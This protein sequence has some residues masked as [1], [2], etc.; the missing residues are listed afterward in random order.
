MHFCT[1]SSA[2][3]AAK[4]LLLGQ[5]DLLVIRKTNSLS[6]FVHIF[7][8]GRKSSGS[9]WMAQS[10]Q[11]KAEQGTEHP[12]PM[13]PGGPTQSLT[14][15]S[16]PRT[17]LLFMT[18]PQS[19]SYLTSFI[20]GLKGRQACLPPPAHEEHTGSEPHCLDVESSSTVSLPCEL[21]PQ[22]AHLYNGDKNTTSPAGWSTH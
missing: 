11:A 7:H 9:V 6:R 20:G 16:A 3:A 21:G 14:T 10:P 17:N 4:S 12:Y 15:G 5:T 18:F 1:G 8:G 2:R 13:S 19:P 22:F